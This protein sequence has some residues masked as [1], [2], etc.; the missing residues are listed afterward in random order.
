MYRPC[1]HS[2]RSETIS[3]ECRYELERRVLRK[4]RVLES[5]EACGK[6]QEA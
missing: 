4:K 3:T 5:A 2:Y 6:V 1:G